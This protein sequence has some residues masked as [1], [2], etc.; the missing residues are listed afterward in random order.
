MNMRSRFLSRAFLL[1]LIVWLGACTTID[2][3]APPKV[4]RGA[5]WALLPLDEPHRDAAGGPGAPR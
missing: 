5:K 3:G 4:E 1:A 2:V